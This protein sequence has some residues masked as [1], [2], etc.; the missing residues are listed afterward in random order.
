[1]LESEGFRCD[2]SPPGPDGGID[3]SAGRGPLGLDSPT[4]LVQVKSGGQVGAPV[5]SQ[6]QGVLSDPEG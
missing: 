2:M 6:L 1:M 3:I 5:V 4:V